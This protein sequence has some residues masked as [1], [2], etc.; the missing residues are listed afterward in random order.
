[1]L[2]N[3]FAAHAPQL[4]RSTLLERKSSVVPLDRL[5]KT[6]RQTRGGAEGMERLPAC[7]SKEDCH[8]CR[9]TLNRAA[10]KLKCE[11][12]RGSVLGDELLEV[13]Q[14]MTFLV[15]VP[16]PYRVLISWRRG[17]EE[18]QEDAGRLG[19]LTARSATRTYHE[20]LLVCCCC[21]RLI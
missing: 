2:Q 11:H 8:S 3:E 14:D 10:R 20:K 15:A 12:D 17:A 6:E 9:C 18:S 5:M 4:S 21:R 1:M 13:Y 19:L 16:T 7:M